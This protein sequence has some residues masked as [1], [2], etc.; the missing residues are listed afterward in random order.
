MS[1][2]SYT[3]TWY[4]EREFSRRN[5]RTPEAYVEAVENKYGPQELD[6]S[7]KRHKQKYTALPK[8]LRRRFAIAKQQAAENIAEAVAKKLIP[9]R[10]SDYFEELYG[11]YKYN[12]LREYAP[13]LVVNF[14]HLEA[15]SDKHNSVVLIPRGTGKSL[16]QRIFEETR[17]NTTSN[18]KP[19]DG[20]SK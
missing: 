7:N 18:T 4:D 13:D 19:E 3:R 17:S 9:K 12:S 5:Y 2:R 8:E 20:E 14:T 11:N 10:H 16:V 6:L 15:L 1:R